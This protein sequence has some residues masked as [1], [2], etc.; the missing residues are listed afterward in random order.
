VAEARTRAALIQSFMFGF[1][2]EGFVFISALYRL[3][4]PLDLRRSKR[5]FISVFRRLRQRCMV[6]KAFKIVC[7]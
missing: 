4:L 2:F 7:G 3:T 6:S 1:L 5:R